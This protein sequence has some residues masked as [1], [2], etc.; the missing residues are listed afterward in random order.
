MTGGVCKTVFKLFSGARYN[1]LAPELVQTKELNFN[2]AN[3]WVDISGKKVILDTDNGRVDVGFNDYDELLEAIIRVGRA[4][5]FNDVLDALIRAINDLTYYMRHPYLEMS[6]NIVKGLLN[7]IEEAKER[8]FKSNF[9]LMIKIGELPPKDI[10]WFIDSNPEVKRAVEDATEKYREMCW[11]TYE[12]DDPDYCDKVVP[13][14]DVIYYAV[15][16]DKQIMIIV[17]VDQ[18]GEVY[19]LTQK[20]NSAY[21]FLKAI[22]EY[23]NKVISFW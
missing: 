13:V 12:D 3:V 9:K 6:D 20:Y 5:L 23:S 10:E 15:P 1:E 21:D 8:L 22:D 19:R 2:D 17:D 16:E 4:I 14:I 7:E 18:V 11:E